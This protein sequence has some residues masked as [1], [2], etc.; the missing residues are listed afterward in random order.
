MSQRQP[1]KQARKELVQADQI[2]PP[3]GNKCQPFPLPSIPHPA[4]RSPGASGRAAQHILAV[5]AACLE[6]KKESSRCRTAGGG[7]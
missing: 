3:S 5:G 2:P 6:A 1:A 4:L 7:G